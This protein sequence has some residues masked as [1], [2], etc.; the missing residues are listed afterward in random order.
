VKIIR[1]GLQEVPKWLRQC[2][3]LKIICFDFN[4]ITTV[5]KEDL[6]PSLTTVEFFSNQ[7]KEID[8]SHLKMLTYLQL[9]A[10]KLISLD[11]GGNTR[12]S[13]LLVSR[14]K[15]TTFDIGNNS[16]ITTLVMYDNQLTSCDLRDNN[17][18]IDI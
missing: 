16:V 6:P 13:T 11:V 8:I 1:E 18:L 9:G 4:Q 5:K 17:S 2:Q 10:N 14:N 7:I 15:L 3:N 12:L